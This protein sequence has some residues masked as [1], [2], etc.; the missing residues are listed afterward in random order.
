M[1]KLITEIISGEPYQYYPLG[2]LRGM[3]S[4]DVWRASDF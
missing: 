3:G 4:G 1:T 2:D